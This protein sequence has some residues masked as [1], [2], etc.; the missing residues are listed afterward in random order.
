MELREVMAALRSSWWLPVAGLVVGALTALAVSLLQTPQYTSQT[1]LFVSTTDS[2]S[3]SDVFQGSQ[4]SQ[5]RVTSY[6]QLLT[7]EELA[8]RVIDRLGLD[9]TPGE[10]SSAVTATAVTDTVLINITVTDP[11]A[12]RAQQVGDA[13]GSEF[14][15]FAAE[16]EATDANGISPVKVTVT[17]TADLPTVPSSPLTTRNVALGGLVGLLVGAALA[18]ARVRLDRTVK[19]AEEA[20]ELAGAPV[21]GVVLKDDMLATRHVI[22]RN[23]T[24]P[25]AE[26]YRQLRTNLQFLHV[27]EPPKVIMISSAVPSE[28]KT[29]VAV[30]LALSLAEAGRRVVLVEGDLRRPRVTRYLGMVGGVG[31]TNILASTA[32]LDDVLQPYGDG[33]LRV[34]ASGPTPP[35]PSELLASSHM[36]KVIDDLRGTN[37]FVLIDAPPLLPVADASGLAVL[38]DG[39]VLSIRYGSTRKEQLQQTKATLDRVGARTLGIILNIVPPKAEISSA[40]GYGYNYGYDTAPQPTAPVGQPT[41]KL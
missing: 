25:I 21:I 13:L 24:A 36:F 1:Q 15:T 4:F 18:I 19:D 22:E 5:Q 23:S 41:T 39:V 16:L 38:V 2:T 30:N 20:T 35:N 33:D 28:G 14:T 6:A 9:L 29:T 3:T 11:S 17:D 10:L 27:D 34:L 8:R 40:Y 12:Q 31:L 37:D 7:G 32:E 26:S